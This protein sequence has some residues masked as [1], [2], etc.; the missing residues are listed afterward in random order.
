[1][2]KE[3]AAKYGKK[4]LSITLENGEIV[5]RLDSKGISHNASGNPCLAGSP[6]PTKSDPD[7]IRIVDLVATSGG[8]QTV[9]DCKVSVNVTREG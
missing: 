6:N 4:N 5:M 7:K 8:F 2:A 9:G 1:M 3:E